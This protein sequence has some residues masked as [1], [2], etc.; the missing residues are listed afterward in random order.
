MWKLKR[1]M[2]VLALAAGFYNMSVLTYAQANEN[3]NTLL[4]GKRVSE[5]TVIQKIT[6]GETLRVD[7]DEMK[8]GIPHG[9]W[10]V[11][12]VTIEKNTG[13]KVETT[14]YKSADEVKSHIPC[15]QEL[16]VNARTATLRYPE[17]IEESAEYTTEGDLTLYTAL[18]LRYRYEIKDGNLILTAIF[19]YVNNDLAARRSENITENWIIALKI[20]EQ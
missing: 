11:A 9:L 20:N 16:E 14:V 15:P 12:E 4:E 10:E 13:G 7:A 1:K 2:T 18:G 19:N 17:G 6:G 5:T 8:D 3:D